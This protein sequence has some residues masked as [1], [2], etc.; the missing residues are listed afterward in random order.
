MNRNNPGAADAPRVYTLRETGLEQTLE[1]CRLLA[2]L[3]GYE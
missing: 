1:G 2:Y 3:I